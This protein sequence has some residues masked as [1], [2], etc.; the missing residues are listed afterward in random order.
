LKA[1]K[2]TK[3][4]NSNVRSD[5]RPPDRAAPA[6]RNDRRNEIDVSTVP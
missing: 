5:R 6:W 2:D 4:T 1:T 3:N